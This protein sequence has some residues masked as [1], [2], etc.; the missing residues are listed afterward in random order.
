MGL[1][2]E[3]QDLQRYVAVEN[4]KLTRNAQ[5]S[6]LVLAL[7]FGCLSGALIFTGHDQAGAVLG[8]TTVIGVV[9]AYIGSRFKRDN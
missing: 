2:T 9:S 3:D 5:L 1:Q 6:S 8:S 4:I 7:F